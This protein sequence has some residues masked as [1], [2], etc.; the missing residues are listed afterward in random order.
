[1]KKMFFILF[2]ILFVI[3]CDNSSD[4]NNV[5]NTN[6]QNNSPDGSEG[7]IADSSY[8]TA[9]KTA[10]VMNAFVSVPS[11]SKT[12]IDDL[13]ISGGMTSEENAQAILNAISA[14][15][16]CVD[17]TMGEDNITVEADFTGSCPVEY[18]GV[19]LEGS[20]SVSVVSEGGT[21]T[22]TF[23]FIDFSIDGL[24]E[25]NGSGE[26]S[27]DGNGNYEL[28]IDLIVGATSLSFQGA[29]VVDQGS[30]Y[31]SGS[32]SYSKNTIVYE[33]I[34]TELVWEAGDCY[35]SGGEISIEN[36][37]LDKSITFTE[38]T[39]QTGEAEITVRNTTDVIVLP[40]WGSCPPEK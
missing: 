10:A 15:S 9:L 25:L 19:N 36:G 24:P 32:A 4:S 30:I 1:M 3:S 22:V 34:I 35:P 2:S 13:I 8:N 11:D 39:P 16:Q 40:A 18:A 37:L 7:A 38:N 17:V 29:L 27:W 14:N 26:I 12:S 28:T 23:E 6:N 21:V 5:N 20:V 33:L 31:L